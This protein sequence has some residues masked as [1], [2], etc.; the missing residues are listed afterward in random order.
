MRSIDDPWTA[1]ERADWFIYVARRR[2]C[3]ARH[4]VQAL[5]RHMP[6]VRGPSE[7]REMV[8]P[9]RELIA[10]CAS[11]ERPSLALQQQI[12][13]GVRPRLTDWNVAR[14]Y[15]GTSVPEGISARATPSEEPLRASANAAL[16][17]RKALDDGTGEEPWVALVLVAQHI[18]FDRA[19]GGRSPLYNHVEADALPA[20][21][22]EA[23]RH[24]CD[25][26]R[27]ELS[28]IGSA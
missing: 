6:P 13:N 18:V 24:L 1:C 4:V 21:E 16:R 8:E 14:Q 3:L 27:A 11:G 22:V 2:G 7:L 5:A 23:H 20:R 12:R 28:A 26:L 10:R 15:H 19:G 25:A 17:L 9:L